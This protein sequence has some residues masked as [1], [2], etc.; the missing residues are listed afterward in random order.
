VFDQLD[1]AGIA[2]LDEYKGHPSVRGL[3]VDG[4]QIITF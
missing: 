2:R 3:V 1:A 4:Y